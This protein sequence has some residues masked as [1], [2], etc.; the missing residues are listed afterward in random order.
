MGVYNINRSGKP[1]CGSASDPVPSRVSL[2]VAFAVARQIAAFGTIDRPR[3]RASAMTPERIRL[4]GRLRA[5]RLAAR[6]NQRRLDAK[7]K[8]A[9]TGAW[10][11]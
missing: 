1:V 2:S 8:Q 5:M 10:T 6:A 7:H 3:F 9:L 11:P 4:A